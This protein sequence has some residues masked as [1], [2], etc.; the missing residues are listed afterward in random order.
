MYRVG[1][2]SLALEDSTRPNWAGPGNRPLI[3]EIGYPTFDGAL[4]LPFLFGSP[5]PL[6]QFDT[7]SI[8]DSS[9]VRPTIMHSRMKQF[10]L[11]NVWTPLFVTN[12]ARLIVGKFTSRQDERP[13][14]FSTEN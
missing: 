7:R 12:I 9:L 14:F 4:T 5:E 10:L 13:R 3:T 2:R 8:V 11:V 6:F 1:K